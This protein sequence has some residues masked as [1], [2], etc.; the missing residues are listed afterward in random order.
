MSVG[1]DTCEELISQS[2][3]KSLMFPFHFQQFV[4]GGTLCSLFFI[5]FL[6]NMFYCIQ[7]VGIFSFVSFCAIHNF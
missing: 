7:G 1:D 5:F 6:F 4:L 3:K 2:L